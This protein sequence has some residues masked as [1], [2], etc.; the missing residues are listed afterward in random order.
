MLHLTLAPGRYVLL[1]FVPDLSLGKEHYHLGM[2]RALEVF[3]EG[4]GT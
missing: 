3:E 1:C 4:P 2:V